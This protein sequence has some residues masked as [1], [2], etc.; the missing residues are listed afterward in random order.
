MSYD[1]HL[2]RPVAGVELL[3]T[4]RASLETESEELNVGPPVPEKEQQKRQ[5]AALLQIVNPDLEI[6]PFD[7]AGIARTS[8]CSEAEAR[9]RYRH[10]ELN[11]A[12]DGNG[13]QV[14]LWD[15]T[16]SITV[17]YWH[18]GAGAEPV[19]AEIWN[20]LRVL[21]VRAGF[22]TYD[23]QLER[24]LALAADLSAVVGQYRAVA[25]RL[26]EIAAKKLEEFPLPVQRP[27]WKFW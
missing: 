24:V 11:G 6:Y 15:D 7:Y 12:E 5:N 25:D 26:P 17:P 4:A 18:G 19:L 22:R 27:W 16:V 23:P 10:L 13:I 1:L 2:F 3:E 21:E 8:G 9:V 20:Y 14:T